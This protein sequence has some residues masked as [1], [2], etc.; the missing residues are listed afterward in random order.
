MTRPSYISA[1]LA[2]GD[3]IYTSSVAT[4]IAEIEGSGHETNKS[5]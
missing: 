5:V 4:N 3:A 2:C 1:A